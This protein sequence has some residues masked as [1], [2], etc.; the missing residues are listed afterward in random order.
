MSKIEALNY[1][2]DNRT[3]FDEWSGAGMADAFIEVIKSQEETFTKEFLDILLE[4]AS[5]Y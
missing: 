4:T 2:V 1:L 5:C 3:D